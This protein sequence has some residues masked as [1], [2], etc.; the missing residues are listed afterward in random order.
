MIRE[1]ANALYY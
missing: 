1:I